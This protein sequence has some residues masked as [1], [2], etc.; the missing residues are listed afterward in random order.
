MNQPNTEQIIHSAS[1]TELPNTHEE[2]SHRLLM[3][4]VKCFFSSLLIQFG[5]LAVWDSRSVYLMC[6]QLFAVILF[7]FQTIISFG[8]SRDREKVTLM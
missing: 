1:G 7:P 6:M 2:L 5:C 3:A 4:Q 8:L